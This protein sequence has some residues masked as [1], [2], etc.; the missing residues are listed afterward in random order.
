VPVPRPSPTT[1]G[2]SGMGFR[3]LGSSHT[4]M[5]DDRRAW[6]PVAESITIIDNRTGESLEIPIENGGDLRGTVGEAASR[7]V[8][9]RS[10]GSCP[11]RRARVPSRSWT[12]TRA[13]SA[14]GAIPSSSWPR[15]STYLEVAYL[16][17]HGEL[18]T[19]E[20]V[21]GVGARGHLPHLHSRERTQAL[22]R[23]LPLRRPSDGHAGIGSG[24]PVHLL[25]RRQGHLRRRVANK[26]IIRLIAKMPT[27]AAAAH[28]FSVGCR[29]STPTTPSPSRPTSCR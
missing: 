3:E 19:T 17:L 13:S 8:V 16:L 18:P 12:A 4:D 24:R 11:L 14:T 7:G 5:S 28:R 6:G 27:L 20:P 26:Q 22:P 29:S 2:W 23:G 9:L 21:R 1:P 15:T 10:R 25:S